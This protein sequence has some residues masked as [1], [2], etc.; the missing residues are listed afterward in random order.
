DA[1]RGKN[2]ENADLPEEQRA[3]EF[4]ERIVERVVPLVQ[5]HVDIDVGEIERDHNAHE[6]PGDPFFLGDPIGLRQAPGGLQFAARFLAEN[7]SLS[8]SGIAEGANLSRFGRTAA[9]SMVRFVWP[10]GEGEMKECSREAAD[11]LSIARRY[12]R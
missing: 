9:S 12:A 4:L 3:V 1:D 10:K 11:C 8:R 5:Q 6:T 7:H 2:A